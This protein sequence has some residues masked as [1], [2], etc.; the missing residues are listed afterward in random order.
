M[1]FIKH[2]TSIIYDSLVQPFYSNTSPEDPEDCEPWFFNVYP[3]HEEEDIHVDRKCISS[4]M[5]KVWPS[6]E[7]DS[8]CERYIY[9]DQI[10]RHDGIGNWF[11]RL[12]DAD[13]RCGGIGDRE[14]C[15]DP[16]NRR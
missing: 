16:V 6:A 10:E 1:D 8:H 2:I 15:A 7:I 4:T 3:Q 9:R 11:N 14:Q 12:D 5:G 13:H